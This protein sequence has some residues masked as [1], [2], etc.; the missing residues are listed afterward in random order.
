MGR[1]CR[2]DE[3]QKVLAGVRAGKK[4]VF[5]NG[6]FDLLHVGHVRYLQ[7]ARKLGD[8]LI[9]GV[10]SDASTR[11]LKGPTRPI[12]NENDRAEILAALACVDFTVIF[13]EETPA[14]L[15]EQVR[16]E[17]L[18]KGGDWKIDQ[19]VGGDFVQSYGGKVL[20]LQFI[21]GRSTTKIIEKSKL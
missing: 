8:Y 4:I 3:V 11:I 6:C 19:I 12:Q 10:N 21:E 5:T 16:P 1:V 18:V 17:I 7:E 13:N 20:S 14:K 15:I 9:V 2:F